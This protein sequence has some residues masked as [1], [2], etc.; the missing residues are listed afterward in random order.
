[1]SVPRAAGLAIS[2]IASDYRDALKTGRLSGNTLSIPL[3]R[4]AQFLGAWE[5]FR[6]PNNASARLLE[7]F[8]YPADKQAR[9][10]PPEPGRK[11]VYSD[12]VQINQQE[13]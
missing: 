4:S 3:F 12:D 6:K 7:R 5:G 11:I 1:M 9:D 2:N 13:L 10:L 8:Y